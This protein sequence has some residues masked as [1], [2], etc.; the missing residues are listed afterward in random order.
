MAIGDKIYIADKQTLDSVK[1]DTG[2]LLVG[3]G[4]GTTD[5]YGTPGQQELKFGTLES[6]Y[7]GFVPSNDL[8]NGNSLAQAIGLSSGTSQNSDA[9]WFKCSI[10]GRILFVAKKTLRN[11]ISWD[12]I[13]S[14]GAVFGG[15]RV[16]IHGKEY[17]VR[18]L[19][20][21]NYDPATTAGGEWNQIMYKLHKDFSALWGSYDDDDL[22]TNSSYGDG[23]YSWCQET[24]AGK[25]PN[26][27]TR[28]S[29]GVSGFYSNTASNSSANYGWRPVLELL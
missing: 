1:Q 6:G 19:T 2:Q 17:M 11:S 7:F 5:P 25:T 16:M 18:L 27:V 26:R 20:G 10:D 21:G 14:A 29:S 22:L 24:S 12:A 3:L 15:A 4:S 8:I 13:Q 9:G 28:G 23:S